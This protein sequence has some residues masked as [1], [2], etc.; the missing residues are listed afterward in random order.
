[1]GKRRKKF[2]AIVHKVI[3]PAFGGPE[4]AQIS[5]NEADDLYREIR[6]ENALDGENG[7]KE[8]LREGEPVDV[9][10]EAKS[11]TPKK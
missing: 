10:I 6:I 1:M 8:K 7:E 2:E 4:K 11:D 3:K 9:L 5:V